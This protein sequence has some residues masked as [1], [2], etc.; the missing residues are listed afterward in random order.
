MYCMRQEQVSSSTVVTLS[1]AMIKI[2]V[3]F[4]AYDQNINFYKPKSPA[5]CSQPWF[6]CN[7]RCVTTATTIAEATE[8]LIT[9]YYNI[10]KMSQDQ[11]QLF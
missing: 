7:P 2:F 6:V 10:P 8:T 11:S 1:I 5:R 3:S 4:F 9:Q